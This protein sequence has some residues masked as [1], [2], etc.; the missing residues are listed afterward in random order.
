MDSQSNYR[1]NID[2]E[3]DAGTRTLAV[4]NPATEEVIGEAPDATEADLDRAVA[5]ARRAAPAWAAMPI[6]ERKARLAALGDAV[7]ANAEGLVKFLTKEQGKSAQ[8]GM[9]E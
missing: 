1:M 8:E 5:A 6:E 9:G 4:A 2:G 3:L 7:F